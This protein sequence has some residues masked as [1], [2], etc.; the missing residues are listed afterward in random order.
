[1]QD[2]AALLVGLC[3]VSCMGG[4][5]AAKVPPGNYGEFFL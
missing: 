5:K 3:L 1:M 4:K 2:F